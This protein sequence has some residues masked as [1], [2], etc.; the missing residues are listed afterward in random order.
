MIRL[1]EVPET[2]REAESVI[3]VIDDTNISPLPWAY[4]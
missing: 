3:L 4:S 1:P 2:M